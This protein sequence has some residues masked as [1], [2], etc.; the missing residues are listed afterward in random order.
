[1]CGLIRPLVI[2]RAAKFSL[3]DYRG[4]KQHIL[5]TISKCGIVI[6]KPNCASDQLKSSQK[7]K[8]SYQCPRFEDSKYKSICFKCEN[9]VCDNHDFI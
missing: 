5:E 8:R 6:E 4:L 2:E 3:N 1:M 7:R 9:A